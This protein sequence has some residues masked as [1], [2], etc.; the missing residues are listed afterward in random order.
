MGKLI[1]LNKERKKRKPRALDAVAQ[2]AYRRFCAPEFIATLPPEPV[3][4]ASGKTATDG[5]FVRD[6]EE[7]RLADLP[8]EEDTNA[9]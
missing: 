8:L 3:G 6:D 4:I 9:K 5:S 7:D 1:R 2:A